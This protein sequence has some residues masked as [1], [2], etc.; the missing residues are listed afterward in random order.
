MEFWGELGLCRNIGGVSLVEITYLC[1]LYST[2]V[3][4]QFVGIRLE[5]SSQLPGSVAR[6]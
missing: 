3:L 5:E 2:L 1:N 6:K 4:F